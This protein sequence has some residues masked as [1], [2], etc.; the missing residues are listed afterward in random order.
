MGIFLVNVALFAVALPAVGASIY[1]LVLT[2][3]SRRLPVVRPANPRQ[4]FDIIVPAHNESAV[5]LRTVMSLKAIAWPADQFRILVIAD[6]CNDDTAAI[7]RSAG[8]MV[9]ERQDTNLRGKGYALQFAFRKS[10]ADNRADAVVVV[11]ADTVVSGN[12]LEAIAARIERGERAVQ[13]HYGVLNPNDSWRTRLLTIATAAFHIVRSRARERLGVSCGIRGNGWCVCHELLDAVPYNAFSLAEDIEYGIALG[14]AGVRVAYADE[15]HVDGEMVSGERASR[16][17][18]QR[19]EHGRFQLIQAK[20]GQ[21]LAAA[22]RKPTAL[23]LDLAFDL[24]VLPLSYVVINV[25]ALFL[26][27][28]LAG[29]WYGQLVAWLWVALS[30]AAALLAYV[31]RGWQLSGIG[32]RGL[33]DL[34][35]APFFLLWKIALMMRPHNSREWVRTDREQP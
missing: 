35:R 31:L 19:W 22:L 5:I 20:T 9:L 6:N 33:V 28:L 13:V 2:L 24:L 34:A 4:R 29:W 18:R 25:V 26:L 32:P 14:L 12:L 3:F 23:C 30:C 15:A 17:Q 21:L 8:A 10:R 11:D 7:A 1:L 16:Q 27:S